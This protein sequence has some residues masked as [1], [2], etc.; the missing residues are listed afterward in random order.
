MPSSKFQA[1]TG[2]N[3]GVGEN[4]TAMNSGGLATNSTHT[5]LLTNMARSPITVP[6]PV[7]SDAAITQNGEWPRVIQSGETYRFQAITTGPAHSISWA[8]STIVTHH[9]FNTVRADNAN[10]LQ[11][12][13]S[14]YF[15]VPGE[16]A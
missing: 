6:A 4:T 7:E 5:L 10:G 9:A 1:G 12:P 3:I 14:V 15:T 8:A 2:N 11:V 13:Q 16:T